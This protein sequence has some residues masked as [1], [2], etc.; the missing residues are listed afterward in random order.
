MLGWDSRT[1][2]TSLIPGHEFLPGN[3]VIDWP[4]WSDAL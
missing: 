4:A 3:H 2:A 1:L